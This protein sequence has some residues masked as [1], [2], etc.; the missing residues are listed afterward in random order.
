MFKV[1]ELMVKLVAEPFGNLKF[2]DRTVLILCR[3][4]KGNF[5]LGAKR[6]YFPERIVRMLGGGVDDGETVAGAAKREVR[7]EMGIDIEGSELIEMAE[8]KVEGKFRDQTYSHS[9]FICFLDS[10]KD[11]YLAGDDVEEIVKYS[12]ADFRDLIRRYSELNDDNHFIDGD[13]TFSWGDYG[14]VYGFVHQV[15]LDETLARGL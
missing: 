5:L 2:R 6:T 1:Y 14:K 4:S 13:Q 3:D 15:A 7:E 9:I 8:V 10:A 12:E 11:D